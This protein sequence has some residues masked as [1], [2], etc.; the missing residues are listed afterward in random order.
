MVTQLINWNGNA[1]AN[2]FV[3]TTNNATYFQS[4]KSV[5]AKW[6]GTNLILSNYWDYSRTTSKHLYIF[7]YDMG[8][9]NLSCAKDIRN[10]IKDGSVILKRVSSLNIE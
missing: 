4:Y 7:L 10:A 1:A 3:I 2:Q 8:F 6:D 5:V 9:H